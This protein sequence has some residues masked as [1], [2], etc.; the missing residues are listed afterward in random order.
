[1]S[2]NT[3]LTAYNIGYIGINE[4]S[5][6]IT[7]TPNVLPHF[8]DDS[9]ITNWTE[10]V[11]HFTEEQDFETY[12]GTISDIF[13]RDKLIFFRGYYLQVKTNEIEAIQKEY[14]K[15]YENYMSQFDNKPFKSLGYL[16][17]GTQFDPY[18][19]DLCKATTHLG[20]ERKLPF[21]AEELVIYPGNPYLYLKREESNKDKIKVSEIRMLH[22][23][24]IEWLLDVKVDTQTFLKESTRQDNP[25]FG[26]FMGYRGYF[27]ERCILHTI[28][29]AY[30]RP[31]IYD[32]TV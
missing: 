5:D 8:V 9:T 15:L 26:S 31:D 2:Q 11:E 16:V 28:C 3:P 17:Y 10:R 25:A 27:N 13:A 30:G 23:Y 6:I 19:E 20:K 4:F 21:P 7:K 22:D 1:M 14:K 12:I 29:N 32:Q 24:P 18:F